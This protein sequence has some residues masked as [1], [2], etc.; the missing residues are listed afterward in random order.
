M[1]RLKTTGRTIY[2]NFRRHSLFCN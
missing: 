2:G 1:L